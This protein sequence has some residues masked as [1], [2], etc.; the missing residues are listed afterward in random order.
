MKLVGATNW[1]IRVP[2]MS[3]GL[4]QGLFGALLA[5][6]L[7]FAM[8]LGINAAGDPSH[9]DQL[10][11]QMRLTGWQVVGTDAVLIFL[12]AAIGTGGSAIAIRRFLDV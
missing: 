6:L 5:A 1:F 3:E 2:F 12:G 4:I 7:V 10:I 9:P 11:T 8:Y